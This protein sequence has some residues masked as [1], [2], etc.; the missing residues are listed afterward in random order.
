L[1][2]ERRHGGTRRISAP[3]AARV[4]AAPDVE[5]SECSFGLC[6]P[7]MREKIR[8]IVLVIYSL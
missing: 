6:S 7:Q 5:L 3:V 2:N 1:T 8:E 4:F